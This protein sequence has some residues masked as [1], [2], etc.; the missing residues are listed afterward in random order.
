MKSLT[1]FLFAVL[2][3]AAAAAET[4]DQPT[5][6]NMKA[7]YEAIY[8]YAYNNDGKIPEPAG[9]NGLTLLIKDEY[10]LKPATYTDPR[11][12]LSQPLPRRYNTFTELENIFCGYVYLG[13][14]W[15]LAD[16][17]PRPLLF[18]KPHPGCKV[19]VL[20]SDGKII[21][22]TGDFRSADEVKQFLSRL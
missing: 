17:P 19:L 15:Q 18:T 7:I 22:L 9:V 2:F 8:D 3:A 6:A 5:R 12:P 20:F 4:G 16:R 10:L 13:G 14:S 11:L 1:L 21:K